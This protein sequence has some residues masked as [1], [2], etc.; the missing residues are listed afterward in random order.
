MHRRVVAHL[1]EQITV[2]HFSISRRHDARLLG[3][4]ALIGSAMANTPPGLAMG[5][6]PLISLGIA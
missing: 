6:G 1:A 4:V 5:E 3:V 2:Q